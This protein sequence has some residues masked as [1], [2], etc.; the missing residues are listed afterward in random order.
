MLNPSDI[1][2][3]DPLFLRD[4]HKQA[5]DTKV[6][7]R[8][9]NLSKEEERVVI[10]TYSPSGRPAPDLDPALLERLLWSGIV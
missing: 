3:L 4:R 9:T 1:L 7:K 6:Q 8:L 10:E 2:A 5:R